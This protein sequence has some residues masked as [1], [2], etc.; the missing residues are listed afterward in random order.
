M[1]ARLQE[2]MLYVDDQENAKQFW[3]E[4]LNFHVVSDDVM[5]DMRVIVLKPT[6]DAETAIVLHDRAKVEAMEMGVNTG[7]PSLMF[8]AQDIDALY[9]DLKAKGVTVGEKIEMNGGIVFNFADDEDHY[10]A[11]RN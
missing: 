4:K 6:A 7:T 10:F 1:I 8:V 2:I 11:V 5:N 3:T 9:E